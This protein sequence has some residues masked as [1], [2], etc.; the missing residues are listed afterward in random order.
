MRPHGIID[1]SLKHAEAISPI[2]VFFLKGNF[3]NEI[4]L[5]RQHALYIILDNSL[6]IRFLLY[7]MILLWWFKINALVGKCMI[8]M[9]QQNIYII[10]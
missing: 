3:N 9:D 1:K 4:Y 6:R 7:D 5:Q 8:N 2:Y 10:L